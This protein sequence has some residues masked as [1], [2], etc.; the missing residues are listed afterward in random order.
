MKCPYCYNKTRIYNSR[1]THEHTQTWRRH[2]CTT[3]GQTFTT[4][5]RIEWTGKTMIINKDERS[6]YS[7]ERLLVSICRAGN[8]LTVPPE[9]LVALTDSIEHM[10][11]KDRFF[12]PDTQDVA[13]LIN[14]TILTLKRF[15]PNLALQ[16]INAVYRNK[17]PLELVKDVLGPATA[18]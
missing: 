5:E 1:S 4:K 7:R 18:A 17:P 16:Y 12:K 10:L 13:S 9:T 14:T 3:C 8:N 6:R 2:R 15:D 11:Q